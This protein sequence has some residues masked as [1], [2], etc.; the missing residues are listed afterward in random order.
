MN[1]E[2]KFRLAMLLLGIAFIP[3]S[4]AWIALCEKLENL[5]K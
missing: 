4:L 5:K 1:P 2:T 3:C